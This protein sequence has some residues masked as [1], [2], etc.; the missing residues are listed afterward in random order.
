MRRYTI[1]QLQKLLQP[2]LFRVSVLFYREPII[3]STNHR[4]DS[5]S[6]NIYQFMFFGTVDSGVSKLRKMVNQRDFGSEFHSP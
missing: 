3:R 6:Q 4:A 1:G 2:F 5:N